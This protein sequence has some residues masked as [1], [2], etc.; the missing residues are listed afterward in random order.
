VTDSGGDAVGPAPLAMA[1]VPSIG[2]L[3]SGKTDLDEKKTS[4]TPWRN[5]MKRGRSNVDLRCR[6]RLR[7]NK[8]TS[9]LEG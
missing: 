2:A 6:G 7:H 9:S 3:A 1:C 4:A 8:K 5:A